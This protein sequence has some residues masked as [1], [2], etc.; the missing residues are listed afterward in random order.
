[1]YAYSGKKSPKYQYSVGWE[2]NDEKAFGKFGEKAIFRI[3]SMTKAIVSVCVMKLVEEKTLD[4]D[5]PISK[6]LKEFKKHPK[7]CVE[8][9]EGEQRKFEE[10]RQ[11]ITV[12]HLLT[13]T[14]GISYGFLPPADSYV[15]KCY[16]ERKIASLDELFHHT[17]E[18]LV[19]RIADCPLLFHP[20]EH[21]QYSMSTDVLGYL[22]EVILGKNLADILREMV[23]QPL[24]MNDTDF[25]VPKE[26]IS[27]VRPAYAMN[28]GYVISPVKG[29][30]S[31]GETET[32]GLGK[33]PVLASGGGGLFSTAE[34]YLKFMGMLLNE[35]TFNGAKI[36]KSETVKQMVT[37]NQ[38]PS[39]TIAESLFPGGY[40]ALTGKGWCLL[41]TVL[42]EP[43]KAA[44]CSKASTGEYGWGGYA[45]TYFQI[46]P[47]KGL[48]Y[49][50][51]TQVL[52]SSNTSARS[53]KTQ[54]YISLVI[55][56]V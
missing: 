55:S 42:T 10:A 18:E 6:Y 2:N 3:F 51:M 1:V 17:S 31:F 13:H 49:I 29:H 4:L 33:A 40:P 47:V 38:L 48:G 36:L 9:G 43:S 53:Y 15:H 44:G 11:E 46:D 28:I 50:F 45:S 8:G 26:K 5:S 41:G 39:S 30:P 32:R 14:S 52:P 37:K 21:Y 7:V 20:G 25:W 23:F 54:I 22:L 24:G 34:D 16:R 56:C 19:K 27:R 35:G 12:R